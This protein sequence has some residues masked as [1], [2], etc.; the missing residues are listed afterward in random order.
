MILKLT[1]ALLIL[2]FAGMSLKAAMGLLQTGS[3]VS[4]LFAGWQ[5]VRPLPQVLGVVCLLGSLLLL[6]P[7]T[8]VWG[9]YLILVTILFMLVQFVHYHNWRGAVGEL[10]AIGLSLV[11]LGL[12]YPAGFWPVT[13]SE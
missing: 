9:N 4:G 1:S 11:I 13:R 3:E 5:V 6:H 8:F 12:G 10:L 7:R 2:A